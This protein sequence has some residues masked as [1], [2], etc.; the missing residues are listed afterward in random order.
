MCSSGGVGRTCTR[1]DQPYVLQDPV[2][3]REISPKDVIIEE[4]SLSARL[5]RSKT[6]GKIVTS[7]FGWLS[8]TQRHTIG[9]EN[10][11]NG[12]PHHEY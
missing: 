7:L 1:R 8:W 12:D 5:S 9:P 4:G 6:I 10:K 2:N 11:A 3:H